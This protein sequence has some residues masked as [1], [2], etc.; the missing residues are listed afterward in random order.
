M[1][2]LEYG[3][4]A[5]SSMFAIV[6]P[7]ATVPAYLAMTPNDSPAARLRMARLAC[8]VAT[9]VLLLFTLAG[10]R[11][12][13]VLGVTLPAFQ[14]AGSLLL[15]RIAFDMLYA[16]RSGAQETEEE[17]AAGTAKDDIAISPLGVPMLAG[18]GAISNVLILTS[19]ARDWTHHGILIA[20]IVVVGGASY[21]VFHI[22][23]RGASFL[24]PLVLKLVTRLMGLVIAAIA[25]QFAFNALAASGLFGSLTPAK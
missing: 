5:F 8:I 24:N 19:Q 1:G 11:I 2:L 17:V 21:G 9:S 12:F 18:P 15:L 4:L 22:A 10:P 3:L 13:S 6:D 7:I 25:V 16:K 20:A 14:L 23:A